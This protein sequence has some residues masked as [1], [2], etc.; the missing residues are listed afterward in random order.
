MQSVCDGARAPHSGL[1]SWSPA[2]H[3]ACR[4]PCCYH[5][6][7]PA[8]TNQTASGLLEITDAGCATRLRRGLWRGR[9]MGYAH[10][11]EGQAVVGDEAKF[12]ERKGDS[13]Y[14]GPVGAPAPQ[15]CQH[16]A[17]NLMHPQMATERVDQEL[18]SAGD[19]SARPTGAKMVVTTR[20]CGCGQLLFFQSQGLFFQSQGHRAG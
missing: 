15:G 14:A 18:I 6:A 7:H 9:S 10:N 2:V 5:G 12:S 3:L 13:V 1:I 4:P 20:W 17:Y 19:P 16:E 8:W 11:P